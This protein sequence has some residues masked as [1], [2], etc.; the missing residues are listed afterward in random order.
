MDKKISLIQE[1]PRI[2]EEGRL[3]YKELS[4]CQFLLSEVYGSKYCDAAYLA[5]L[6]Y[7][8]EATRNSNL[9]A[10]GNN[11]DF[12][13][14]LSSKGFNGKLNMIYIDPPFFSKAEYDASVKVGTI[15]VKHK[16]YGDIWNRSMVEYL[17]MLTV[18]LL[19]MHDLLAD[20]GTI[21]VHLD[22]HAVHYVKILMDEI[23]G[24]E[25]FVNEI[26]WQYK[27]GGSTKKHFSRKHDTI[28]AYSKSPNYFFET[29]KEKS[30][31]REYKPYRFK[32][33]EEFQDE[34]GW[35]T[36]VNM[37]DVW[38]VDMV[39]RTSSE[40]TGYATQKPE[41][42]ISRIVEATTKEGDYCADFFCGSGTLPAV[43]AKL[44][45]QFVACDMSS[46][47]VESTAKRLCQNVER[48][49][50]FR[51]FPLENKAVKASIGLSAEVNYVEENEVVQVYLDEYKLEKLEDVVEC[52]VVNEVK[53]IIEKD[54]TALVY[55]WAVDFNYDKKIFKP[56]IVNCR[57]KL[58]IA[59]KCEINFKEKHDI[60]VKI[61]D[62]FGNY[63]MLELGEV[64]VDE[65][66]KSRYW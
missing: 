48:F 23:F 63:F 51:E 2:I 61:V 9:L 4:H 53:G 50:L 29:I 37:K 33:V 56:E 40:R 35:Y 38:N 32:N 24:D 55:M 3:E 45:R 8:N 27:S 13:R 26:I 47:A 19:T 15:N 59:N 18:R 7:E 41:V 57:K 39:G 28:L 54:H 58:E 6:N 46:L 22:W 62:V 43:A 30:Y 14:Y 31:N 5:S 20:N 21:W 1:L 34:Q 52:K 17:K 25:N 60:C 65:K 16:A 11:L 12:M 44:G 49:S 36:M 66:R 64:N 10:C 42:L